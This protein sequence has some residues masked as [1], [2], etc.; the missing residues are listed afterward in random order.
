ML[1]KRLVQ[2]VVFAA[3]LKAARPDF[4]WGSKES[5]FLSP[6]SLRREGEKRVTKLSVI[7]VQ[8]LGHH[9]YKEVNCGHTSTK[10]SVGRDAFYCT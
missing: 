10:S 7:F 6:H 4:N 1:R 3:Q 8:T 9:N 2:P 5:D